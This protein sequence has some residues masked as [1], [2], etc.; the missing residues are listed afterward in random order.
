MARRLAE[1]EITSLVRKFFKTNGFDFLSTSAAGEK[2]YYTIKGNKLNN[3]QP[4][5]ILFKDDLLILCEDK[6]HY[7]ALFSKRNNSLCDYDKL[8][9]FLESERDIAAF[10]QRVTNSAKKINFVIIGC[11]SS[12]APKKESLSVNHPQLINLCIDKLED[13]KF[14][15]TLR[16]PEAYLK[17]FKYKELITEL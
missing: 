1:P 12:L 13:G 3:K 6:I 2:L 4:D 11:L 17:Y 15:I 5:S 16:S 8:I 10:R 9:T 7:N 14:K